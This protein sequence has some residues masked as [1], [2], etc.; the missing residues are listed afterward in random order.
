MLCARL[1]RENA[2]P[3][4]VPTAAR[5]RHSGL[6]VASFIFLAVESFGIMP[7]VTPAVYHIIRRF[8][9][10]IPIPSEME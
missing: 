2:D 10:H 6:S 8:A 1:L 4:Q 3:T 5:G 9:A 7:V